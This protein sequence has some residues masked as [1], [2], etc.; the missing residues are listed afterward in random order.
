M[1][2]AGPDDGAD[3]VKHVLETLTNEL[4]HLMSAAGVSRVAD[5]GSTF[6]VPEQGPAAIAGL[7]PRA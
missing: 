1:A 2:S 6:V 5:I 7:G 4:A 3:G